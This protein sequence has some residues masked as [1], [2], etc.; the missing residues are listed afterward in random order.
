MNL[1][2]FARFLLNGRV[3]AIAKYA[4][5]AEAIQRGVLKR[6]I[7]E[8]SATEWGTRHNYSA[9]RQYEQ[10]AARVGL[11]DYEALKDDIDRMRQGERDVLWKGGCKWFAKSSGT[12]NDKSKFIPVTSAGL[13]NVHYRGAT[14]VV[15]TYIAANP[16]SRLLSGKGLIL[17]GSHS[18]NYNLPSSLVGD[19]SAILI[20]NC[21]PLVNM[22]RVPQKEVALLGDFEEK[23][24]RIARLTCDKN[25]TN[26][27]GV[28][29]WMMAVLKS[30]KDTMR[31]CSTM[32]NWICMYGV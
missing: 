24:D 6:L 29:S 30:L 21:S 9:I 28:P 12:T 3:K 8:A 13:H 2:P 5:E 11:Q 27:S 7:S 20:E 16:G 1:T 26:L 18:S 10:F 17:G 22:F 25:I 4:T 15:A 23:M 19:L 14:D 32:K 31:L